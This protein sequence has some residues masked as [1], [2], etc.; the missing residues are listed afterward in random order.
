MTSDRP[1]IHPLFAAVSLTLLASFATSAS[2]EIHEG[3][4]RPSREVILKAPVDE[5]LAEVLVEQAQ[6][7]REGEVLAR[8]SDA[9]Q[10]VVVELTAK[11]AANDTAKR[12]AELVFQDAQLEHERLQRTLEMNAAN[13]MEVL[14]AE[15]AVQ[16]AA[17]EIE[18]AD[19]ALV[20]AEGQ[21]RLQQRRLDQYEIKAPFDGWVSEI[22][23]EQGASLTRDDEIM[24]LIALD[25]LE[26][27]FDL[28]DTTYG[29]LTVGDTLQITAGAPINGPL[30]AVV[31]RIVPRIDPG[32]RTY[33]AV[34]TIDNPNG[35][36]P[37]GFVV[38]LDLDSNAHLATRE[39]DA[40]Q[41]DS[42]NP[43]R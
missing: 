5:L 10:S 29:R 11:R 32:S 43:S 25:P 38:T 1:H 19:Q 24:Q 17:V 37:A 26:A 14:R 35:T 15:I 42:A 7:V 6:P 23:T 13:E 16:R 27:S 8:M 22:V 30:T 33:R 4:V 12:I 40:D 34:L 36:L 21:T 20:E 18:A 3:I 2:A 39:P 9:V 31:D 41:S 28:P